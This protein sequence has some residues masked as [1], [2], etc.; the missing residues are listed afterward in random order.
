VR[1]VTVIAGVVVALTFIF[2][3]GN[4]WTLT[5]RLVVDVRGAPRFPSTGRL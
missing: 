2:G 3:F 5:L 4:V 1:S